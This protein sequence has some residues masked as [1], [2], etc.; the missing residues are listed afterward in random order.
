[1]RI[2]YLYIQKCI[3]TNLY[4]CKNVYIFVEVLKQN[5]TTEK[6]PI[7]IGPPVEN[8]EFYGREKELKYA[9]SLLQRGMSLLL[10]APRRVGKS[11][12]SKKMLRLAEE[13]GWKTLYL[14]LQGIKTEEE[15][16]KLLKD[17][18]QTEKWWEKLGD[19]TGEIFKSIDVEFAGKKVSINTDALRGDSYSKIKKLIESTGK[20]LIV[21]DELTIFLNNLLTQNNGKEKVEFFLNWLRS[22]RQISG[23]EVRWIFCSSVG[24]ENFASMHQLSYTLNDV[25]NF[26]IGA[27]SEDEAKDFITRLDVSTSIKF[28]EKDIQHI[29]EKISW[30]LPFFIQILIEKIN[31]LIY[32]EEKQL[33][34]STIDEAYD[35]LLAETHFN[36]WD[37]RLSAYNEFEDNARKILKLCSQ[38]GRSRDDLFANLFANSPDTEKM[39]TFLAKLLNMLQNDGYLVE[40][41]G[42]YIFRSPLL[43]DFWIKRYIL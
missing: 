43:R 19:T 28:K 36:S 26:P 3:Y 1:M 29:L 13:N 31:F 5:M 7:K 14:D 30:Y 17:K 37:D 23:T 25:H 4:M 27:Y 2:A 6:I 32:T 35:R 33:S 12:F 20:I 34:V 10:S 21:M 9:W 22:F 18:L 40:H 38:G 42:K 8:N 11:S 15:F 24:I 41:S 16:I 39:A